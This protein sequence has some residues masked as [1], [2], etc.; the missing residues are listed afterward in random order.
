MLSYQFDT[1]VKEDN[2]IKIPSKFPATAG[3]R[4]RVIIVDEDNAQEKPRIVNGVALSA[5]MLDTRG[6]KF[7]REE[8]NAR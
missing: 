8:A 1:V 5:P 3:M 4:L 6:W 7:D 2:I